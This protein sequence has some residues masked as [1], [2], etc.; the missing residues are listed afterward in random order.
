M[1]EGKNQ[2]GRKVGLLGAIAL[3]V[4]TTIGSGIF[5]SIAEVAGAA[6]SALF[7]I[8]AF[9][10][11]AL[12]A[13]PSNLCYAELAS[14]YPEDGGQ[15]VYFREAGSR[16]M[17]FLTGWISFWA[18]D[19]TSISIWGLA[20]SG[21]LCYI[22]GFAEIYGT[23]LAIVIILILMWTHIRSVE[24][25]SKIQTAMTIFKILPFAFIIIAGLFF[26]KGD[27]IAQSTANVVGFSAGFS[28]LVAGVSA[29]TWS[30]DGMAAPAYM[31]GEIKDPEKNM[32]RALII[33]V[34]VVAVVYVALTFVVT[35]LL[36]YDQLV[37]SS[38]PIAEAAEKISFIGGNAGVLVAIMGVIVIAGSASSGIMFQPRLEYAM[39]H[40]GLFFKKFGEVS[41]YQ[42]PAFSIAI[43]VAVG[44]VMMF[45][46]D[47]RGLLGYFTF[48]LL[49]KN[50]LTFSTIFFLR[51]KENYHPYFKCPG[52]YLMPII[53]MIMTGT[54]IW[55]ELMW[56]P[57][58][59]LICAV[60][61]VVTGYPA[62]VIWSKKNKV[63]AAK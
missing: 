24:V 62:Y 36:P 38:A 20:I 2:L 59:A 43:Q 41:K 57:I 47:I 54:L 19:P 60:I 37:A 13:L 55:G 63:D 50:F 58:P 44:I 28:A 25:G 22:F 42:T 4:G 21:Y 18:N 7:C 48:V 6:G 35:D 14:A 12:L 16:F 26:I 29:T 1:S 46:S 61:A 8:L 52:G 31:G 34:A 30:Y 23:L 33:C 32:P 9:V 5:S 27:V 11:G 45:L 51:K 53:A 56:A 15:Y 49:V 40:D 17:A 10:V 3:G 39:A